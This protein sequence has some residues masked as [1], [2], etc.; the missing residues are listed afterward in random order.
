MDEIS[1]NSSDTVT[2]FKFKGDFYK[3]QFHGQNATDP[4]DSKQFSV[5]T[6]EEFIDGMLDLCKNYVEREVLFKETED[7]MLHPE[8]SEKTFPE[9]DELYRYVVIQLPWN[10]HNMRF[11]QLNNKV[12]QNW[13]NKLVKA[14]IYVYGTAIRRKSDFYGPN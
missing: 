10:R 2:L 7:G 6:V 5:N 4:I 12:L 3:K 9:K 8:F 1:D 14:F 11:E 13:C